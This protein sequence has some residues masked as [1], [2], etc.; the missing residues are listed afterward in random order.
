[1]AFWEKYKAR[2]RWRSLLVHLLGEGSRCCS[3]RRPNFQ[4]CSEK[5]RKLDHICINL[6]LSRYHLNH[7]VL[8]HVFENLPHSFVPKIMTPPVV[9]IS[10]WS[11]FCT[12]CLF[13]FVFWFHVL[14]TDYIFI[15][16]SYQTCLG[17]LHGYVRTWRNWSAGICCWYRSSMRFSLVMFRASKYLDHDNKHHPAAITPDVCIWLTVHVGT[18]TPMIKIRW[19]RTSSSYTK[20]IYLTYTEDV[21]SVPGGSLS[22]L[23]NCW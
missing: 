12:S 18:I 8:F 1:M 10:G 20:G 22:D 13:P 11:Y 3:G 6:S 5:L 15:Q 16:V 17:K 23:V 19:V 9:H 21:V 4:F 2:A 7:R 14:Q